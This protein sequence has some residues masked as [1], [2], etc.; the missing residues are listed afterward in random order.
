MES[1][2]D[3]D[4]K[5]QFFVSQN[6]HETVEE[7]TFR[8]RCL[9]SNVK[10]YSKIFGDAKVTRI[11]TEMLDLYIERQSAMFDGETYETGCNTNAESSLHFLC[12][13]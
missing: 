1:S 4:A 5:I 12:F 11:T 13:C 3:T 8:D 7:D 9:I 2:M 10:K 6:S